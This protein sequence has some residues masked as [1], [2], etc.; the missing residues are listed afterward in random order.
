[1]EWA[2]L[3]SH[4]FTSKIGFEAAHAHAGDHQAGDFPGW[5]S[6]LRY[7]LSC[8]WYRQ[9]DLAGYVVYRSSHRRN[10]LAG[11]INRTSPLVC[12]RYTCLVLIQQG[13]RCQGYRLYI[14]GLERN[15]IEKQKGRWTNWQLVNSRTNLTAMCNSPIQWVFFCRHNFWPH[16]S[17]CAS[18]CL[19]ELSHTHCQKRYESFQTSG[20][21]S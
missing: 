4:Q 16:H 19:N 7:I 11:A 5:P 10:I 14:Q 17:R 13:D 9:S 21:T 2:H 6:S 20:G 8:W 1:M 3:T 15:E 12:S 18:H